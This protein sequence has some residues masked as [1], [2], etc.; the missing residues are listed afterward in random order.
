MSHCGST[1][2]ATPVV[3]V[4]D[5]IR[6]AAEILV[7]HLTEQHRLSIISLVVYPYVSD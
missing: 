5:Q 7:N 2:A 6:G 3:N 1:T 4:P